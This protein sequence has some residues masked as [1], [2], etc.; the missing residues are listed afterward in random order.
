[1]PQL[2][3]DTLI[4]PACKADIILNISHVYRNSF[5][6]V[7]E[8]FAGASAMASG[9]RTRGARQGEGDRKPIKK[10]GK[11]V[12]SFTVGM[13]WPPQPAPK[14]DRLPTPLT[15]PASHTT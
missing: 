10:G 3:V 12:N 1:M 2:H 8:D 9:V 7:F 5:S 13:V 4:R 15:A 14:A 6:I 11:N